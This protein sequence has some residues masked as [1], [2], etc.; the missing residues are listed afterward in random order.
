MAGDITTLFINETGCACKTAYCLNT[1]YAGCS[2][3]TLMRKMR[4]IS[5]YQSPGHFADMDM[6]EIGNAN[7]T[8]Y[9]QQTHFTFWSALKSPLIIGANL[10]KLSNNS[11]SVLTNREIISLNQDP[12]GQA[13]NYIGSASIEGSVQVWAGNLQTGHVVLVFNEKSYEQNVSVEV[14]NLGFQST[15]HGGMKELWSG[16]QYGNINTLNAMLEPYQTIVFKLGS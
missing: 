9:Q 1:G 4:E 3:V 11:I 2:V 13:V 14:D 12:L 7:M 8:V 5:Q 16:K 10:S 15:G 6:L